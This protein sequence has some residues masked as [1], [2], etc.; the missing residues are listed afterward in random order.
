MTT[1]TVAKPNIF[2]IEQRRRQIA[3]KAATD[4]LPA[5]AKVPAAY[6]RGPA[7]VMLPFCLPADFAAHNLLPT[8][9]AP[10]LA[11]FTE[12]GIPWHDGVAGGPSGHLLSSQVQCVNALGRMVEDEERIKRAFGPVLDIV[13]VLEIEPGRLLTF[14]FIGDCD[15]FNEGDGSARRRGTHCTSVD[16]AFRYRTSRGTVELALVEWKY[17]ES[18]PDARDHSTKLN[19]RRGRYLKDYEAEDGP[20]EPLL[21]FEFAQDEPFYQLIRQQLLAHRLEQDPA[22]PAQVVR[23]VHVLDPRNQAYQESLVRPEHRALGATVDDVWRRI[24]RRT[25]RFVHLDPVVFV[26]PQV[27]DDEYGLRY[28]A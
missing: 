13:E 9:R 27:T 21:A 18:Y 23:V 2:V 10:M 8:V 7:D 17:T 4:T 28:G 14:E 16:G 6:T 24:L 15:Y 19:T 11:L 22:E 5:A 1:R 26:D 12:L 25:D 3:W 20:V